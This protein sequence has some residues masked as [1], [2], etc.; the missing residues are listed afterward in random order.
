M[1]RYILSIIV[2]FSCCQIFAQENKT[3]FD[4]M[5]IPIDGPISEV[6]EKLEQKGFTID[7]TNKDGAVLMDGVFAN[8][9]CKILV[10]ATPNSKI[11][12]KVGVF[13]DKVYTNW[14]S[15]TFDFNSIKDLYNRKYGKPTREFKNFKYPYELGD[16]FE[17]TALKMDHCSYYILYELE[18]GYISINMT[19]ECTILIVYEDKQNSDIYKQET[20][21]SILEDI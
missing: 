2:I 21:E 8:K 17:M 9:D 7:Q 6:V 15:I 11:A 10:L 13:P 3:H 14:D 12:W 16:G 5:G 18:S 4:F 19:S 1:K 20:E